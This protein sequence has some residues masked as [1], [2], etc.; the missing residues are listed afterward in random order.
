LL[1]PG[2]NPSLS[3]TLE[4]QVP[5]LGYVA[6]D[7]HL[8]GMDSQDAEVTRSERVITNLTEGL[9]VHV[10]T[11]H[12]RIV[13]Y[14]PVVGSL[15][16][17]GDILAI[18][19]V[20]LTT[21]YAGHHNI[22]PLRVEPDRPNGGA[23]PCWLGGSLDELYDR[24]ASLGGIVF[25]LAHGQRY[26]D[27][28]GFDP[29]T[30]SVRDLSRFTWRFNAMEIQNGK[31]HESRD[32][33]VPIWYALLKAGRKVAP[34]GV[35]DSHWRIPEPGSAR[36]YVWLGQDSLA[37]IDE[38]Q[39]AEAVTK[40]RTVA[41]TGPVVE[42]ESADGA[43]H[44]GDSITL[45]PGAWLRLRIAVWAP[46][47]MGIDRV[48][49]IADGRVHEQWDATTVPAVAPPGARAALWFS[50]EVALKPEQSGFY[51][52]E[53]EGNGDLAPVLPYVTPWAHT[54]PIFVEVAPSSIRRP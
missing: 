50:H 5:S 21:P 36:T 47:W 25:Q 4:R 23:I 14:R 41:S 7:S 22:W 33:L 3:F 17:G 27:N 26:F 54:A 53:V 9:D 52:I 24:Y 37:T 45:R 38:L 46:A 32:G 11:D 30:G 42:L 40:L 31:A 8:H 19:S 13:D 29:V 43:L 39:I 6:I 15:G 49:L 48:K 34:V 12:D 51:A 2:D 35:S 28:A 10:A 20:E 16:V 1:L 18:P 44:L